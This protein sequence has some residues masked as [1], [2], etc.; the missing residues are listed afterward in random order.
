MANLY[1]L[2]KN[3]ET[4]LNMLYDEEIDEQMVLDTLESIEGDIEDKADGYAKIIK[5]LK[6]EQEQEKKKQKDLQIA[7]KF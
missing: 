7:K 5:E 1:E 3:Y 2:T 4:V 6:Q